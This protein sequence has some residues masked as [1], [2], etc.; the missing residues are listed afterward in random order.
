MEL[1]VLY[2]QGECEIRINIYTYGKKNNS[3]ANISPR[4]C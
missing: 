2:L 1:S 4:D 3:G